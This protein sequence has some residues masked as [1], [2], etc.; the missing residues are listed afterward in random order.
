MPQAVGSAASIRYVEEVTWG[1]T[2]T[3]PAMKVLSA[4]LYGESLKSSADELVS[5]AINPNRG[6]LDTRGGQVKVS[7]SV[8]FELSTNGM[9]T[10]LKG[11]LGSNVSSAQNVTTLKYT[12]TMKRGTTV[13]SFTIEKAFTDISQYFVYR[14]CRIGGMSLNVNPEGIAS[15]TFE[16]MGKNI[17]T[18]STPLNS[19]LISSVHKMYANFEGGLLEGGVAAKLLNFSF[20]IS[21]GLYDSRIVGSRESAQIGVGKS[22]ITGQI[23]VMFEDLTYFSKWL[24]ETESSLK[25]KYIN[26]LNSCEFNFPRVKYNGEGSPAIETQEGIVLN[27]NF[28]ALVDNALATDVVITL[29]NDEVTV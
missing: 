24:N 3:T 21:N 26:G 11:V 27:L 28:R 7:G 15:G 13:P 19:T 9:G 18:S 25:L 6:I 29:I 22:E 20:N 12:H 8:P 1:V 4:S 17:A 10:I 16:V 5:N 23:T 2:P 14:G